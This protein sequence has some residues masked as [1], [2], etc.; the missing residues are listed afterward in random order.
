MRVDWAVTHRREKFEKNQ[1]KMTGEDYQEIHAGISDDIVE[2]VWHAMET[3]ISSISRRI[4]YNK[5]G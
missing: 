1:K 2:K 3:H 5:E 4:Y